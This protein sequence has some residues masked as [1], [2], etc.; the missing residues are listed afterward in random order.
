MKKSALVLASVLAACG[1]EDPGTLE[2][3][4]YG[5]EFI[6]E[7]IPADV[8]ADGW[9]VSFDR[10]LVSVSA[11]RAASGH[12]TAAL[13]DDSV[14]IFDLSPASAGN[15]F[16]VASAMVDG[17]HY[18]HVAYAIR[19]ATAAAS[20]GNAT[21]QDVDLMTQGGYSLYVAGS[22]TKGTTTK[23]FAW[24]FSTST[25]YEECHSEAVVDGG[26]SAAQ[27]TVHAD[28]LFYDDLFSE[29]PEVQFELIA[30]AD[31]DDNGVVTQAE[32]AAVNITTLPDYQVG[33]EPIAD[34]WSFIEHQTA[35]VGHIDGEGHC[36]ATRE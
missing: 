26:T 31:A 33:S 17:G 35:T 15:G 16:L 24:G 8:F 23:T 2:V 32:L 22:A 11:V 18:D 19:P 36:E 9:A 7:G 12:G 13:S 6:E 25:R 10:F 3:R 30:S 1:S 29:E 34:L 5:E 28:H 4:I 20:A 14:R 27:I 21:Q